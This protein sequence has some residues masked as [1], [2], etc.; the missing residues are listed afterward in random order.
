LVPKKPRPKKPAWYWMLTIGFCLFFIYRSTIPILRLQSS[1]PPEFIDNARKMS[2]DPGQPESR[3]ALAYWNVAVDSIQA[4]YPPKKSLPA[5][6]PPEFRIDSKL[7]GQS[8]NSDED[9]AIYWHRLRDVWSDNEVWQES[10]GWNTEWFMDF[11]GDVGQYADQSLQ[12]FVRNVRYWQGQLGRT[13]VS[14]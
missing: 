2:H 10:H 4:K 1:P 14:S 13:S 11:L 12:Q 3:V 6:P 8:A 9:R 5:A 7:T